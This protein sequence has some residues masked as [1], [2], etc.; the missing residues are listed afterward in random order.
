M[1]TRFV[2]DA[3][4]NDPDFPGVDRHYY[5][6]QVGAS[7]PFDP[8]HA[9]RLAAAVAKDRARHELIKAVHQA[10]ADARANSFTGLG[11][12]SINDAAAWS[13]TIDGVDQAPD[14]AI[15]L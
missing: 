10:D 14:D 1:P 3:E 5:E 15:K 6:R 13:R 4:D 12:Q 2:P 8:T 9:F 11:N 7:S